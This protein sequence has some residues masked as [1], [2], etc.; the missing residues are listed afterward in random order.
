MATLGQIFQKESFVNNDVVWWVYLI[1]CDNLVF[2]LHF[3]EMS[4]LINAFHITT[5]WQNFDLSY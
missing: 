4:N 3:I 5:S 1:F 2:I